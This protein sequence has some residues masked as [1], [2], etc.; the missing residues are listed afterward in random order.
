MNPAP[1][2]RRGRANPRNNPKQDSQDA[3]KSTM[4]IIGK[5]FEVMQSY[6]VQEAL[7]EQLL[8][9]TSETRNNFMLFVDRKLSELSLSLQHTKDE[10]KKLDYVAQLQAWHHW[11]IQSEVDAINPE[12]GQD[13]RKDFFAW[14]IGKGHEEDHRR[15]PWYRTQGLVDLPDVRNYIDGFVDAMFD[16]KKKLVKLI[17]HTPQNLEEAWLYYKF[18]IHREW[19][20]REDRFFWVDLVNFMNDKAALGGG[21]LAKTIATNKPFVVQNQ[22]GGQEILYPLNNNE[23]F[24]PSDPDLNVQNNFALPEFSNGI[25]DPSR[26][27]TLRDQL[28][29]MESANDLRRRGEHNF[30]PPTPST[31]ELN[32]IRQ[33]IQKAGSLQE[34]EAFAL[35]KELTTQNLSFLGSLML[36]ALIVAPH[37]IDEFFPEETTSE[38]LRNIFQEI[39][40]KENEVN[41]FISDY[42]SFDTSQRTYI[43]LKGI[44]GTDEMGQFQTSL[45]DYYTLCQQ[46][47]NDKDIEPRIQE[48]IE[49]AMQK[50]A[51]TLFA[52]TMHDNL[53]DVSK[54]PRG[55]LSTVFQ[56]GIPKDE[57]RD[58]D[59]F[60]TMT[61]AAMLEFTQPPDITDIRAKAKRLTQTKD[62]NVPPDKRAAIENQI[63]AGLAIRSFLHSRAFLSKQFPLREGQDQDY[64][65]FAFREK[66]LQF[67]KAWK[68]EGNAELVGLHGDPLKMRLYADG[69]LQ[70]LREADPA[71]YEALTRDAS[72]LPKMFGP[73]YS[74]SSETQTESLDIQFQQYNE[75][76]TEDGKKYM[77][78]QDQARFVRYNKLFNPLISLGEKAM[79]G[80]DWF[81]NYGKMFGSLGLTLVRMGAFWVIRQGAMTIFKLFGKGPIA[82]LPFGGVAG[83]IFFTMAEKTIRSALGFG[84]AVEL[85]AGSLI[86]LFFNTMTNY[87]EIEGIFSKMDSRQYFKSIGTFFAEAL[88][89]LRMNEYEIR[90]DLYNVVT[91]ADLMRVIMKHTG[92]L[93]NSLGAYYSIP[94]DVIKNAFS[95][96]GLSSV[97]GSVGGT[98]GG[99]LLAAPG[100][101][102]EALLAGGAG[103]GYAG[104]GMLGGPFALFGVAAFTATMGFLGKLGGSAVDLWESHADDISADDIRARIRG[105]KFKDNYFGQLIMPGATTATGKVV[106]TLSQISYLVDTTAPTKPQPMAE[107]INLYVEHLGRNTPMDYLQTNTTKQAAMEAADLLF[108]EVAD[109]KSKNGLLGKFIWNLMLDDATNKIGE[110]GLEMARYSTV[111]IDPLVLAETAGKDNFPAMPP[112]FWLVQALRFFAPNAL[113]TFANLK[114]ESAPYLKDIPNISSQELY[115]DWTSTRLRWQLGKEMSKRL[116]MDRRHHKDIKKRPRRRKLQIE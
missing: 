82:A 64:M 30:Y 115:M 116:H 81:A 16:A 68:L 29:E 13:A 31:A 72:L 42:M 89:Q 48:R 44:E 71:I 114:S 80:F 90:L 93:A 83:A 74:I 99:A 91:D 86:G 21:L 66:W 97:L 47:V 78:D 12:E 96:T 109:L 10:A 18:V 95:F 112:M 34:I 92:K 85:T 20:L 100:G 98:A 101:I 77:N 37:R 52:L 3:Q 28:R 11:K 87:M 102:L 106:R 9:S 27:M 67:V 4:E 108:P 22:P 110:I 104:A 5:K 60:Q 50:A 69:L 111:D 88:D 107:Q 23:V 105:A 70:G 84:P 14:L 40:T 63:T 51:Q 6:F 65:N 61:A 113:Q 24:D 94:L 75:F 8:H 35:E 49:A 54:L 32:Q 103:Y 26:I 76:L 19:M 2:V 57:Q 15:T 7:S 59:L 25:V 73:L 1:R 58:D 33:N 53:E 45:T 55:V 41:Q 39:V 56:G 17:F 79:N 46:A 43:L 62:S 36:A 38:R